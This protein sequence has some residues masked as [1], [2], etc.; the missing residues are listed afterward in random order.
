MVEKQE[1]A[2]FIR[3]FFCHVALLVTIFAC[4]A[5]SLLLCGKRLEM[6]VFLL[7][8]IGVLATVGLLASLILGKKNRTPSFAMLAVI[9]V[10]SAYKFYVFF[11]F[12]GSVD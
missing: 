12:L 5:A 7:S 9:V 4:D 6:V 10:Y 1:N 8:M 11:R 2:K 3:Q